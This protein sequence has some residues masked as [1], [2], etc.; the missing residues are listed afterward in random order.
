M[1]PQYDNGVNSFDSISNMISAYVPNIIGAILVLLIG[2]L[3]ALGISKVVEAV[4]KKTSLDQKIADSMDTVD[5]GS[6]VSSN[7]KT[8]VFYLIMLFVLIAFFQTLGLTLITNPLNAMLSQILEFLPRLLAAAGVFL[9]FW[10]IAKVVRKILMSVLVSTNVDQK[11]S[12]KVDTTS[13]KMA[14]SK[15]I[16]ETAYWLILFFSLPIVL[17][18]LALTSI[19]GPVNLMFSQLLTYIPNIFSA[20]VILIVGWFIAKLI[21]KIV[22]NL[23]ASAG[24]NTL[25]AK[26][27]MEQALAPK[28]L[29]DILGYVVYV[30]ILIP[31]LVS[32]LDALKLDSIA[33]PATAMLNQ[34]LHMIPLIFGAL[35]ILAIAIFIAKFTKGLVTNLLR[36]VGFDKI[37]SAIGFGNREVPEAS[38]PSALVGNLV[39]IIVIL[40]ASIE[41]F[42]AIGLENISLLLNQIIFIGGQILMGLVIIA[43]GMM[44]A[45]A[46]GN[47]I[48]AMSSTNSRMLA[49][50]AK[51]AI[52]ILTFAMGLNQMGLAD[53]IINLAFGLLFGAI[54]V[55]VAL[56]FGLGCKDIAAEETKKLVS[57][58]KNNG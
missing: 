55:A 43:I 10:L 11:L 39:F 3:V 18:T 16:S 19:L 58:M 27:N 5:H 44:L 1:N 22:S 42:N 14:V 28:K 56:A 54:A 4:L 32:A 29:S 48:A 34:I 45:N 41:A 25:A 52:I 53:E 35:V 57:E 38:M 24:I 36:S 2:W 49:V 33:V 6:V 17:N 13:E 26:M 12:S 37:L 30:L 9:I 8:I 23:L 7:A 20:A 46:A 31:V 47:A 21:Y 51:A 50:I 40:F 15:S